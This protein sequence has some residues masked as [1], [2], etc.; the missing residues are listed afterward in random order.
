MV[1]I[2]KVGS[3]SLSTSNF[4]GAD[5]QQDFQKS[6][7]SLTF[8][9]QSMQRSIQGNYNC[10]QSNAIGTKAIQF[11]CIKINIT[12]QAALQVH[13]NSLQ[14]TPEDTNRNFTATA[15]SSSRITSVEATTFF[16]QQSTHSLTTDTIKVSSDI[17]V[18]MDEPIASKSAF[19]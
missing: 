11:S 15:K 19:Y 9:N 8:A 13:S 12:L 5:Q 7:S 14:T 6:F 2:G 1:C 3:I 16:K 4:Q 10:T 17:L 18:D